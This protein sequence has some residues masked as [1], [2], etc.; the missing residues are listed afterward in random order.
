LDLTGCFDAP[1]SPSGTQFENENS[2][3]EES[4]NDGKGVLPDPPSPCENDV[5][6]NTTANERI[7][8]F[9]LERLYKFQQE[10]VYEVI[11]EVLPI[12][13]QLNARI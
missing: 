1:T 11:A 7:K 8:K 6:A 9:N 5:R 10:Y 12:L 2:S 13:S 4:I 3:V